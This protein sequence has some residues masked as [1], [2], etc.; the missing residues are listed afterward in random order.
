MKGPAV[1]GTRHR[2]R[3]SFRL[4]ALEPLHRRVPDSAT[5]GLAEWLT[6]HRNESR[7]EVPDT[8]DLPVA[9]V[10]H[11]SAWGDPGRRSRERIIL[12]R[13][14]ETAGFRGVQ[15]FHENTGPCASVLLVKRHDPH[16]ARQRETLLTKHGTRVRPGRCAVNGDAGPLV[17]VIVDPEI[18]T[19]TAMPGEKRGMKV[20]GSEP[21]N[22]QEASR[23]Y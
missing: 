16:P 1:G 6:K 11:G 8:L 19:R 23:Q 13:L 17:V 5:A 7:Q 21:R 9:K 18:G 12:R 10:H 3:R 22:V 2:S 14:G 15:H 4:A 20:H